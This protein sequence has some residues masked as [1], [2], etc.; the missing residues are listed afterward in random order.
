MNMEIYYRK[1]LNLDPFRADG[2]LGDIGIY[3]AIL[4]TGGMFC[5]RLVFDLPS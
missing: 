4:E 3:A 2:K 5:R 1:S